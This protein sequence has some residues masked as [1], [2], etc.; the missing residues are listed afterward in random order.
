M[1]IIA[2]DGITYQ[3][4]QNIMNLPSSTLSY[5]IKQLSDHNLISREKQGIE[6]RYKVNDERVEKVLVAYSSS[7]LDRL[8]DRVLFTFVETQFRNHKKTDS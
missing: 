1:L 4:L 3:D 2:K 6:T 8:V 5:Y 7:F